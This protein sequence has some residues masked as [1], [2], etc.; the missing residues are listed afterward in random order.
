MSA[1]AV[2]LVHTKGLTRD[3]GLSVPIAIAIA[4]SLQGPKKS[5]LNLD[6]GLSR[7]RRGEEAI[8]GEGEKGRRECKVK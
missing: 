5:G 3:L 6:G 8:Q 2:P 1:A 4:P 7:R